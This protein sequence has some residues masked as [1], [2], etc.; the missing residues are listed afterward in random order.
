[1]RPGSR[2]VALTLGVAILAVSL[3]PAPGD[4]PTL[5][6]P[7]G[8]GLDKYVHA[9]GYALLSYAATDAR[10]PRS[11]RGV[12]VV[13]LAVGLYGAGVELAQGLSPGRL[14]SLG[15]AVANLLGAAVGSA[16]WA[17]RRLDVAEAVEG[18]I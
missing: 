18:D 16:V 14:P 10:H 6:G 5:V 9:G 11:F 15:D 1:M 3:L 7:F 2:A 4:A 17:V 8:V 13:V 12:A